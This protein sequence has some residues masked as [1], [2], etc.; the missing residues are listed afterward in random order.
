MDDG[1]EIVQA[2]AQ[3]EVEELSYSPEEAK[4]LN[5][6]SDE[7]LDMVKKIQAYCDKVIAG[8]AERK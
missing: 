8:S 5:D 4:Y 6:F 3:D 7:I 1:M 2:I